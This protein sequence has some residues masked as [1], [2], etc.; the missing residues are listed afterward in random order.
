MTDRDMPKTSAKRLRQGL[1]ATVLAVLLAVGA[2]PG[3][4]AEIERWKPLAEDGLHDP[5]LDVLRLL[6][7]P[8]EALRDLPS[9]YVG[10]KVRWVDA[11]EEGYIAPR[12][13]LHPGTKIQ[14]LDLDIILENTGE[15]PLVRFPHREHTEWLDC[16]NCHDKVFVAKIGANPINM[17]AILTGEYCGLCHGAVSFPLVECNRCHSVPRSTFKGSYGAQATGGPRK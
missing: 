11:L 1:Q 13:N 5:T 16:S 8:E 4:A 6:Q 7:E 3:A 2:D 10:N 9:D 15:M 12:T 17:L 14:V